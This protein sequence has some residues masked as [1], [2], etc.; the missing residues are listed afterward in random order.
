MTPRKPSAFL[1]FCAFVAATKTSTTAR[2]FA[3]VPGKAVEPKSSPSRAPAV[4][5]SPK[6]ESFIDSNAQPPDASFFVAWSHVSRL[7][8]GSA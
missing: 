4:M 2:K 5:S 7:A 8:F 1:A 6:A 3:S